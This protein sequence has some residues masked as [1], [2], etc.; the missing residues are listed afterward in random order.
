MNVVGGDV[1]EWLDES[2]IA[3]D[4]AETERNQTELGGE[5]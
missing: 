5:G 4:T 2:V 3:Q 1:Q